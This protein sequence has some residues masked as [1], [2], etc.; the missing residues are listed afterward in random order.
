MKA[1]SGIGATEP[2]SRTWNPF[3]PDDPA[4]LLDLLQAAR[5][6]TSIQSGRSSIVTSCPSFRFSS[7]IA[8]RTPILELIP[9]L[10][11]SRAF[12]RLHPLSVTLKRLRRQNA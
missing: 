11:M 10:N 12:D 9:R 6:L 3:V 8:R 1:R 4:V 7:P 5:R 2:F